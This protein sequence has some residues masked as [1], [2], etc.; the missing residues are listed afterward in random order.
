MG[1]NVV[2][3][4]SEDGDDD[5]PSLLSSTWCL[6]LLCDWQVRHIATICIVTHLYISAKYLYG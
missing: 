4:V 3:R 5:V 2:K 6:C 1:T